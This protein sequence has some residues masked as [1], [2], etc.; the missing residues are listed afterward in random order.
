MLESSAQDECENKG[1]DERETDSCEEHKYLL[2]PEK[3]LQKCSH[4]DFSSD[5]RQVKAMPG[6]AACEGS[7]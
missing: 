1:D 6:G 5:G 4:F 2:L 7:G 3:R